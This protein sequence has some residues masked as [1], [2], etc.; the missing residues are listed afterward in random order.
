MGC[1]GAETNKIK[2]TRKMRPESLAV[3]W[4]HERSFRQVQESGEDVL[5]TCVG[6]ESLC[7]GSCMVLPKHTNSVCV[8]E[9]VFT[10]LK[11]TLLSLWESILNASGFHKSLQ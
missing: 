4:C 11:G 6:S 8:C 10:F 3:V 2:K 1:N 5:K 9:Y 7:S